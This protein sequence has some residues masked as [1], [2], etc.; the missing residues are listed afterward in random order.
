LQRTE[1]DLRYKTARASELASE[2]GI[3]DTRNIKFETEGN[4]VTSINGQAVPTDLLTDRERQNA[5]YGRQ[6]RDSFNNRPV[7]SSNISNANDPVDREDTR[8][9]NNNQ[10]S[11]QMNEDLMKI[12]ME[13]NRL[14]RKQTT[15][16]EEG[17]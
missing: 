6:L 9:N 13:T 15:V 5:D 1:K 10:Q 17:Q 14:L 12:M 7:T 3:E 16:I 8:N 2:M 4:T 11:P